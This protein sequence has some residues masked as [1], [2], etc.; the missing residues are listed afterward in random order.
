ME[1]IK[2]DKI[3]KFHPNYDEYVQSNM[4]IQLEQGETITLSVNGVEL[5]TFT[6]KNI[7]CSVGITLLDKGVKKL[8]V[9][10]IDELTAKKA[11]ID[12]EIQKELVSK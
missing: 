12:T 5:K 7:N 4:V 10:R 11:Y 3:T 9:S 8:E 2:Q 1:I 6:A